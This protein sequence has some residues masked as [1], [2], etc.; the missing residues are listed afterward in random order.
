MG[1]V[2]VDDRG[3]EREERRIDP[4]MRAKVEQ[5]LQIIA[6]FF[7]A[8][9]QWGGHSL[10]HMAY[11]TLREQMPTLTQAEVHVIVTVAARVLGPGHER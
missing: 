5:A 2:Y 8:E 6:P 4:G 10:D 7:E 11:R 3:V 9:N 1:G